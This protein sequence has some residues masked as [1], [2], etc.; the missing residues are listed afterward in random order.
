MHM[1]FWWNTNIEDFLFKGCNISSTLLLVVTCVVFFVLAVALEWLRLLQAKQRQKELQIR[2]RQI[3][4]V[5]PATETVS[6]LVDRRNNEADKPNKLIRIC[7]KVWDAFLW[8]N[9][10]VLGY[11]VMLVVMIYNGWLVISLILG[12]TVG[13]FFFGPSFIKISLQNCQTVQDTFCY[14]S[15]DEREGLNETTPNTQPSTS[16]STSSG[17]EQNVK[18]CVHSQEPIVS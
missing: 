9:I 12:S 13:Y 7:F 10:Q 4:T 11:I 15:C 16:A 8:L 1:T 3:R 2:A 17:N 18:A 14:V 6:L 5:C